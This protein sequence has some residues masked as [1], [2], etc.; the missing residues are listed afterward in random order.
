MRDVLLLYPAGLIV[1]S[2]FTSFTCATLTRLYDV[3]LDTDIGIAFEQERFFI[4][5]PLF[6][7]LSRLLLLLPTHYKTPVHYRI[8]DQFFPHRC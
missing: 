4:Q 7:L 6:T 8:N 1:H 2:T 5:G 3:P